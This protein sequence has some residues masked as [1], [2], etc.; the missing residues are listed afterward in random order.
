MI[1]Y[2]SYRI[3]SGPGPG[4]RLSS[5]QGMDFVP[6]AR[7]ACRASYSVCLEFGLVV[8]ATVLCLTYPSV[9]VGRRS[10]EEISEHMI[11]DGLD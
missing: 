1:F 5:S 4:R 10:V 11:Y 6:E 3:R 7:L 8:I 9:V 2:V